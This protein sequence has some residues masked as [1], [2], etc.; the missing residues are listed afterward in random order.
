[1]P[2]F[3]GNAL[4]ATSGLSE[5]TGA[6]V[7]ALVPIDAWSIVEGLG[8]KPIQAFKKLKRPGLTS[9][10]PK[11]IA[12]IRFSPEN[13]QRGLDIKLQE[14]CW[15]CPPGKPE[16]FA[17]ICILLSKGQSC[18]QGS[19]YTE[20]ICPS[21]T[22]LISGEK[23]GWG[24]RSKVLICDS[25]HGD[26]LWI[27]KKQ[28]ALLYPFKSSSNDQTNLAEKFSKREGNL[29]TQAFQEALK[30]AEMHMDESN[31]HRAEALKLLHLGT[32]QRRELVTRHQLFQQHKHF[33]EEISTQQR[34]NRAPYFAFRAE[35]CDEMKATDSII[36]EEEMTSKISKEWR[37]LSY[38]RKTE[39]PPRFP[40]PIHW[41]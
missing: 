11:R 39:C 21:V 41:H 13:I 35:R 12:K 7:P 4:L 20:C 23:N 40:T 5:A 6:F 32:L 38:T 25:D 10:S 17:H 31:S 34:E 9:L 18:G 22:L 2:I 26:T 3:Q 36:S 30:L 14:L 19:K 27:S 15:W 8:K 1:M 33:C 28:A 29:N 24:E 37:A 16:D